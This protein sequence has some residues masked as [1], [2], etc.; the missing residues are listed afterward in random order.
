MTILSN[1]KCISLTVLTA[2]LA[3]CTSEVRDEG[4]GNLP[5]PDGGDPAA[6]PRR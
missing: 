3:A 1:Y 4:R 2:L 5:L 6:A